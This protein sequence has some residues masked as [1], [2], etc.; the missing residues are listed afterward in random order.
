MNQELIKELSRTSPEKIIMLVIDGL[1]GLPDP[2]T[3]KSELET[4]GLPNLDA[5]TARSI[6]GLADPVGPGITPGSGPGHLAVFGYDPVACRIGRGALEA[7]GIDIDLQPDDVAARGNFCTVDASGTITDRR[8]GRIATDVSTRLCELLEKI[9]IPGI[10]LLVKPVREHRFVIVFRGDGL[11][12][13]VTETDPSRTGVK[14]LP[15]EPED[16]AGRKLAAAANEFIGKA[17]AVLADHQPANMILLR[18]F[19]RKPDFPTMQ[20]IYRL[21]PLAIA[22][23]PMYRG[24]ARLVGM[25]VDTS[26]G[27]T[28]RDEIETLEQNYGA[29]DFFFVHVKWTDSAGEDGDFARKVKVLEEVDAVIPSILALKPDVLVV[30]G[31]HST[32]AAVQGHSWH[33]VP[34]LISAKHCRPDPVTEFTETAFITGGLGRIASSQIMPIAMANAQKLKKYGA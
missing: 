32:P 5:L 4:A 17:A 6:C 2:A 9:E 33:P 14:P 25:D 29:Y 24:L 15:V 31:D 16:P 1:G 19:A 21:N 11:A 12:A 28:L 30:T 8:A 34:V 22:L 23:Y 26:G 20:E 13:K 10:T 3:G 18:G 7:V 27:S